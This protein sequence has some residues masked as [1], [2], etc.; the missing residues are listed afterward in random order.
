MTGLLWAAALLLVTAGAA[1]LIRPTPTAR[2]AVDSRIPG[3]AV[4]TRLWVVRCAGLLEVA[5]GIAVF[6][7]GGPWAAAV[8]A[9]TYSA[10]AVVARQLMR[11]GPDRDC[12]CFGPASE[13]VSR[14]HLVVNVLGAAIGLAAVLAP[15]PGVGPAMIENP[16]ETMVLLAGAVVL[17]RLGQLA[18]TTLPALSRLRMNLAGAD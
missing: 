17:S 15:V 18:M 5:V 2:A 9:L 16:W 3:S 7:R 14:A 11:E 8:L 12:G 1:K 4:M 13:P 6:L 10:L